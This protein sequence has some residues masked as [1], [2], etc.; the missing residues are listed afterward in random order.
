[1]SQAP[2]SRNSPAPLERV[3]RFVSARQKGGGDSRTKVR[4]VNLLH[5][6]V[7][8]VLLANIDD[9]ELIART[10]VEGFLHGL[11]RSPYVGF[12]VEFASHREYLPGDD[13]RHLNWKLYARNDKLYVKQYDA[14]TN[15]DCH[16][17]VDVSASMETRSAGVSKRR[18]ATMLAAAIAHLALGQHDAVGVTL[19]ADRVL[20]HAKPRARVKQ[21]EEVVGTM[22]RAPRGTPAASA[23]V[24]HEVAELMPRRGLVVL[25]SDLFFEPDEVFSGLD[26]FRFHGH[27]LLI[28]HVLD[29]IEHRLPLS[30]HVNFYDLETREELLTHVD[31]IRAAYQ[32]AIAAWE[33]TLDE[34]CRGREIDRVQVT[35]DQPLEGALYDYLTKRAQLY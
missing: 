13:L 19:F 31:E 26:H 6:Y 9:L 2:R 16:L 22:A 12:S 23:G 7:D 21:L 14:E 8:P 30:G 25:V 35:T 11:H 4:A 10:V 29:P 27:D 17:V 24:L 15:L 5:E 20:A 1:M 32:A 18:Y 34:G 33:T 3:Q 28:F